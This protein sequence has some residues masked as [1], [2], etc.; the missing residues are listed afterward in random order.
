MSHFWFVTV[1]SVIAN[2]TIEVSACD[3]SFISRKRLGTLVWF[4]G[5]CFFDIEI[6]IQYCKVSFV[7]RHDYFIVDDFNPRIES[8]KRSCSL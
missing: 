5:E 6:L 4:A 7:S 2:D 1:S 3:E 8:L